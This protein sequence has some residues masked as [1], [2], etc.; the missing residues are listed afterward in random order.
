M[1]CQGKIAIRQIGLRS[2]PDH[3][4]VHLPIVF[5]DLNRRAVQRLS[6]ATRALSAPFFSFHP[7][8]GA[9][10][11]VQKELS[12]CAAEALERFVARPVLR[13]QTGGSHGKGD[14]APRPQADF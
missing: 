4:S 13:G 9:G 8:A 6:V 14:G 2:K 3:T 5:S 12:F 10:Y 7:N 1:R 11:A